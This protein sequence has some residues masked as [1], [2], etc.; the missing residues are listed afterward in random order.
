MSARAL[1]ARA[2][3]LG[4]RVASRLPDRVK[5]RLSG[6]PPVMLDGPRLDPQLQLLRA[7]RRRRVIHGLVEPTVAIGRA[8]RAETAARRAMLEIAREGR[9]L[10]DTVG[11]PA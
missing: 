3:Y 4:A 7:L 8:R 11:A 2:Q 6:E 9:E 1:A 5:V 10:L